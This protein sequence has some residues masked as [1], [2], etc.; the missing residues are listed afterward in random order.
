MG[1]LGEEGTNEMNVKAI[2]SLI[3]ETYQ[4]W[5]E[6][7]APRLAASLA[8]YT[9]FSLAPLLVLIIAIIG[10]IIG[11]NSAIHSQIIQQVSSTTGSQGAEFVDTLIANASQP[12]SGTI[13]TLLGIATLLLGATGAF[14][15]L[16]EALNTIWEVEP[17]KKGG[18]LQVAKARFLSFAM[19]LVI[20]FFLLV[21]LVIS[22]TLSV[23]STYFANVL[24][25]TGN[26]IFA[27]VLNL[28]IS[29]AIITVIFA[30][31][32]KLL[33][34]IDIAWGDV[35]MG[36]LV[37]A[38]LFGI[39]KEILSWY[40]SNGAS[41]SAY[42]AAGSLV[43]LLLWIYYSA[44]ILF[45]GAEFTQVYA[46]RHGSKSGNAQPN[47]RTETRATAQEK[48]LNPASTSGYAGQPPFQRTTGIN[49]T[50]I[51]ISGDTD[52][53]MRPDLISIQSRR[54]PEVVLPII[55]AGVVASFYTVGKILRKVI[56]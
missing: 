8:Y 29:T 17:G 46:H 26:V 2:W 16:Q 42:G 20:S 27:R 13:A 53:P 56:S 23:M 36:A 24:G 43:V 12:R 18:I 21:S 32:F 44:Q 48:P 40:L 31:I 39:G 9:I 49:P 5:N 19:V 6:D 11:N 37:T 45:L 14:G 50:F 41:T 52:Q 38:V 22:S 54:N 28:V 4:E 15:Q 51:P 55:F 47:Q 30:L 3:R 33:P 7:K 25:E 10:F 34:D 35:W 1:D